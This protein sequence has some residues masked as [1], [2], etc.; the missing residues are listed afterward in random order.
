M[1]WID[2]PR[3]AVQKAIRYRL[4]NVER[5][6]FGIGKLFKHLRQRLKVNHESKP[7]TKRVIS[8]VI[9]FLAESAA[10]FRLLIGEMSF[11]I[12]GIHKAPDTNANHAIQNGPILSE[13]EQS[14]KEN[15]ELLRIVREWQA[16][17]SPDSIRHSCRCHK[18][19][20]NL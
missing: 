18:P 12:P 5:F 16:F 17:T 7:H 19:Q 2:S 10:N 20:M 13:G 14:P 6:R 4:Q 11:G 1:K 8:A 3:Q 9:T 15:G